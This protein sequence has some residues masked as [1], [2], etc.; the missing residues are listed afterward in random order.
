MLWTQSLLF[1]KL[2]SAGKPPVMVR[3]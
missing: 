3:T 2:D 1:S